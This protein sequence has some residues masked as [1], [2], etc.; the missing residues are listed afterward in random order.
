MGPTGT[1]MDKPITA[2]EASAETSI[3]G[4]LLPACEGVRYRDGGGPRL[5]WSAARVEGVI[6]TG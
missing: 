5:G 6:P 4:K 3:M 1:V 2:L